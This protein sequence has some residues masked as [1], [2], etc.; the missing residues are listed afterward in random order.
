MKSGTLFGDSDLMG[1][2]N[3]M[4]ESLYEPIAGQPAEM[5]SLADIGVNT[6]P[7]SGTATYSQS[8]V[9]GQLQLNTAQLEAA[10]QANPSGVQQ[11]LQGWAKGF[12]Q[13]VNLESGPG[14]ALATRIE[15]D[16]T[17][18]SQLASRI[19]TM[20]EMLAV[21][22]K[23]LQEQYAAM[24]VAISRSKAEGEYLTEQLAALESSSSNKH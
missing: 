16:S 17:Q 4:R 3:S 19:D 2:L 14:G 21:R 10:I 18:V 8:S 15:G 7:P 6:G 24:E 1:L 20:N 13:N 22:Q 11:M 23:S 9:E 12:Q 5:S